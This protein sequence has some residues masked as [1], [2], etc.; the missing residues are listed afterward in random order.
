[1]VLKYRRMPSFHIL[2]T[3]LMNWQTPPLN[4]RE[5]WTTEGHPVGS[6]QTDV[7]AKSATFQLEHLLGDSSVVEG[8]GCFTLTVV[9]D[10]KYL[11]KAC[12]YPYISPW[13]YILRSI[14][15]FYIYLKTTQQW[16]E[17][18]IFFCIWMTSLQVPP[19][20]GKSQ[21]IRPTVR[22]RSNRLQ[23]RYHQS[24]SLAHILIVLRVSLRGFQ[25]ES[26]SYFCPISPYTG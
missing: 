21:F 11:I 15:K 14:L 26:V 22:S 12:W 13:N 3:L 20:A 8:Q 23:L 5:S 24:L 19:S 2:P 17:I 10:R 7:G 18:L 16:C 25:L 9:K 4:E 1:M 6:W